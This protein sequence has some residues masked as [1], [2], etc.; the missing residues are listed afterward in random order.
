MISAMDTTM[1]FALRM[2][3][4]ARLS[5]AGCTTL[6][7]AAWGAIV[8]TRASW[9]SGWQAVQLVAAG[10]VIAIGLLTWLSLHARASGMP[11]LAGGLLLVILGS[12]AL[13]WSIH[14]GITTRDFEYW[15]MLLHLLIGSQG[16]IIVLGL[17]LEAIAYPSAGPL[18]RRTL[19]PHRADS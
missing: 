7:A 12:A 17:Y 15:A 11:L 13:I 14:V 19:M 3:R 2:L 16:V 8:L 6:A 4:I 10:L 9:E 5:L 18:T 1:A